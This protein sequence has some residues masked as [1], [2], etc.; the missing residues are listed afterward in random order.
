M[1]LVKPVLLLTLFLGCSA[2]LAAQS[3]DFIDSVIDKEAISVQEAAYLILVASDNLADDADAARAFEM[4]EQLGWARGGL[5]AENVIHYGEFCYLLMNSFG[6]KGSF[7]YQLFPGPRY[8][9]R[10][11]RHQLVV[12]GS[13]DPWMPVSGVKAM[14]M[15]G[16]TFDIKGV[17]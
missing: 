5:I 17:Q 3:N 1:R 4:L 7:L 10:E 8:A 16:R 13:A 15:I 12:Q 2:I 11:L 14:R 9:Y 6:I